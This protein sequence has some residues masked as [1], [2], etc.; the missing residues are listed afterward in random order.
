VPEV[1]A[2]SLEVLRAGRARERCAARRARGQSAQSAR[3]EGGRGARKSRC[4]ACLSAPVAAARGACV[5][6]TG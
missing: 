2:H 3:S 6:S 4:M 1:R 5:M